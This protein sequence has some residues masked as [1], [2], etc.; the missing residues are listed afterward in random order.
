MARF[1]LSPP[2][3]DAVQ[4]EGNIESEDEI[5]NFSRRPVKI[6]DGNPDLLMVEFPDK[7][8]ALS[9]GDWLIKVLGGDLYSCSSKIFDR[10]YVALKEKISEVATTTKIKTASVK[11]ML[12]YDYSHFEASMTL[13]NDNGIEVLEV[14]NARKMCQRLADKAVGQYKTAKIAASKRIDGQYKMENFEEQ[15]KRILKKSEG[16]RTINELAM[17]KQYENENWQA[18]FDDSYDYDD[19]DSENYGL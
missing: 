14:D 15:C 3:V 10:D 17:L 16:D 6:D 19:D 12:S 8:I 9:V 18:Q 1:V 7:I 11:V 4:W 5:S 2:A 13:E